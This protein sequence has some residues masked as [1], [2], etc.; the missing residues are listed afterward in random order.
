MSCLASILPA[1]SSGTTRMSASPATGAE[2][3]LMRGQRSRWH[4]RRQADRDAESTRK[5][6]RVLDDVALRVE[7]RRDVHGCIGDKERLRMVRHVECK[8]MAHAPLSAQSPGLCRTRRRLRLRRAR[9]GARP[10][11]V[12]SRSRLPCRHESVPERAGVT[13]CHRKSQL[14]IPPGRSASRSRSLPQATDSA[15]AEP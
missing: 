2:M 13:P 5:V 4:C 8:H 9:H 11:G 12:G 3:P 6:D 15:A 7:I 1:S 10:Q 14:R